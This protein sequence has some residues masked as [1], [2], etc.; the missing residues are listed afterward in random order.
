MVG[1]RALLGPMIATSATV[2]AHP[3]FWL[4]WMIVVGFI[5]DVYDGIL[6]RHWK[7]E[8]AALRVGDS[9]A[10]TVFYV[11]VLCALVECDWAIIRGQLWL[12][13]A[14]LM[15]EAVRMVFDWVKFRRMASYHS[16]ASKVWGILLASATISF[17]CFHGGVWLLQVA[18][19]WGIL[20]DLEGLA[21]SAVLPKWTR[22]VKHLGR[23]LILRRQLAIEV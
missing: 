19:V 2:L 10:D 11:G 13:C 6:A 17:L 7:T 14:L 20:C 22:D 15:L 9:I 4:G 21:M 12:I 18:L 3:E 23:A 16:Y 8:D 1:F 5:S